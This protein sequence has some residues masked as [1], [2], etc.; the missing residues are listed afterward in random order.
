MTSDRAAIATIIVAY[1][2]A[3]YLHA[4]LQALARQGGV[5]AETVVVENGDGTSAAVAREFPKVTVLEPGV[6]LGFA[7]GCNVAVAHTDAPLL[8][9][10]NPDLEPEPQFLQAITTPLHDE[11]VGIAGAK[12]RYPDGRLQHAGGFFTGPTLLAQHHGYGE[13]D[14]GQYDVARDVPFV[15][16]AALAIRR[17]TWNTL[18]GLDEQFFPAYY[19]D[20][21]L[22]WRAREHGLRV[23]YE[24]SAVAVHH[25]AVALGKGSAAY[26]R[27]FHRNRLR[28]V[29]KHHDD[30]WLLHQWL[31]AELQ[32]LRTTADDA[33]I[34]ALA[35]AYLFWQAHF[36]GWETG[37]QNVQRSTLDVQPANLQPA[38]SELAWTVAQVNKKRTVVPQPFRSRWPF[39]ARARAWLNRV[40]TEDYL[41]PL[42]Q[43]QNDYNA[44]LAEAISAL[45]RQRRTTDA[46]IMCQAMLLAKLFHAS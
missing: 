29:F 16:G 23:V 13:A 41:R 38:N 17:D 1:G 7:G 20:A 45:A 26:Q 31:P 37:L 18:G 32:H 30:A 42:I 12:L 40:A 43:Q 21:E 34:D 24:P 27:L 39:V 33:E 9:L 3:A 35:E 28:F 19:E 10:I 11:T 36:L 15:T 4:T 8:V 2:H 44:A 25:E 46:A 14:H 5:D 22:C 6:N